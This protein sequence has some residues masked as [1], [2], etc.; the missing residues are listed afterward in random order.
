M[1]PPEGPSEAMF[2]DGVLSGETT[3]PSVVT[4]MDWAMLQGGHCGRSA[5]IPPPGRHINDPIIV[6]RL[7]AQ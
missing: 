6:V 1:G 3:N 7:T 4:C 5:I 2:R